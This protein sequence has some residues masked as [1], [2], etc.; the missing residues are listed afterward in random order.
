MVTSPKLREKNSNYDMEMLGELFETYREPL[1]R[2]VNRCCLRYGLDGDYV[3]DI[4]QETFIALTSAIEKYDTE[5]PILYFLQGIA[6][7]KTRNL[8]R[9]IRSNHEETN[10]DLLEQISDD[11]IKDPEKILEKLIRY[12]S[13][14]ANLPRRYRLQLEKLFE[15]EGDSDRAKAL[16]A[17]MSYTAFRQAKSRLLE[18]IKFVQEMLDSE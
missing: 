14:L 11:G 9:Q 8:L 15:L 7:N 16:N 6:K 1:K 3:D 12:Q 4:L 13:L 10:P 18:K 17:E 2:Y 5:R